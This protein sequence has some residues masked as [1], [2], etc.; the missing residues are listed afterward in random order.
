MGLQPGAQLPLAT[1]LE[2][3]PR[4]PP[5]TGEQRSEGEGFHGRGAGLAE[6]GQR[7]FPASAVQTS[8]LATAA[9]I[10]RTGSSCM[11]LQAIS[12][13]LRSPCCLR[14]LCCR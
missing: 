12:C 7:L 2:R 14:A 11:R 4:D 6:A 8:A 9:A 1:L 10:S 3:L 13:Q 5:V